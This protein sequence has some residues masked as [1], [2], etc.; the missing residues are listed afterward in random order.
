[1]QSLEP[2]RIDVAGGGRAWQN[3]S[4]SSRSW[5]VRRFGDSLRK[6]FSKR[7]R[8]RPDPDRFRSSRRWRSDNQI[9]PSKQAEAGGQDDGVPGGQAEADGVVAASCRLSAP[10]H[11]AEA[12]DGVDQLGF[13]G[14]DLAGAAGA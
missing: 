7:R 11:V 8:G 5:S 12:A 13:A 3:S 1:M 9:N 4:S 2:R 10:H 14:V 6:Y